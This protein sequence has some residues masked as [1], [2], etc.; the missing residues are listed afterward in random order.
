MYH[1]HRKPRVNPNPPPPPAHYTPHIRIHHHQQLITACSQT[2]QQ[3][4]PCLE[5]CEEC[6]LAASACLSVRPSPPA[7]SPV[8][9]A[10][11]QWPA[12]SHVAH[13]P[14]TA[15]TAAPHSALSISRSRAPTRVPFG[16]RCS[17]AC[18][19]SH[20]C[21]SMALDHA[22]WGLVLVLLWCCFTGETAKVFAD[23]LKETSCLMCTYD[24]PSVSDS[25]LVAGYANHLD[26]DSTNS[27]ILSG[28]SNGIY[29]T[30]SA[31]VSGLSNLDSWR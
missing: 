31:I 4:L 8:T 7:R 24:T 21:T 16:L 19:A 27:A 11:H 22:F 6:C 2:R 14:S 20:Q 9:L 17:P 1:I 23:V 12:S 28:Q 15:R 25:A 13:P 29:P 10:R 18:P 30:Q 5:L 3:L 26:G